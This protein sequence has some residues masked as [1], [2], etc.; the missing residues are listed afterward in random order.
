MLLLLPQQ[1]RRRPS[2]QAVLN[3]IVPS[4]SFLPQLPTRSLLVSFY[5]DRLRCLHTHPAQVHTHP[6]SFAKV[7][8]VPILDPLLELR[9]RLVA[10]EGPALLVLCSA[11]ISERT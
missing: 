8:L 3:T 2:I 6:G 1:A 11:I 9:V 4:S 7:R 10:Y 5:L